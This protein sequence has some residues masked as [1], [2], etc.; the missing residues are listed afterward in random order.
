VSAFS[1]RLVLLR[2]QQLCVLRL[3]LLQDGELRA[4]A[5][6]SVA[7][8]RRLGASVM[9]GI[10]RQAWKRELPPRSLFLSRQV[11]QTEL[12][13]DDCAVST[14]GLS[15]VIEQNAKVVVKRTPITA[16]IAVTSISK[17]A[18]TDDDMGDALYQLSIGSVEVLHSC[19]S[20]ALTVRDARDVAA[21]SVGKL[22]AILVHESP[23]NRANEGTGEQRRRAN[24]RSR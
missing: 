15:P 22:G 18:S 7:W 17:F 5:V 8:P 6:R 9:S 10:L 3:G 24:G 23:I 1:Y 11:A 4:L 14:I 21:E 12:S 20:H 13:H 16:T 2:L 19:P